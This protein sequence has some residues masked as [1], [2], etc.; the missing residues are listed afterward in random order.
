MLNNELRQCVCC[1]HFV[2]CAGRQSS[3]HHSPG[4]SEIWLDTMFPDVI[5][6]VVITMVT[7]TTTTK[8]ES[9]QKFP[10][11]PNVCFSSILPSLTFFSHSSLCLTCQLIVK[12]RSTLVSNSSSFSANG[13]TLRSVI[14]V[15]GQQW[16]TSYC[17]NNLSDTA[18]QK[19]TKPVCSKSQFSFLSHWTIATGLCIAQFLQ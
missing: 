12:D 17:Q 10:S 19:K 4:K 5:S 2:L 1:D 11:A 9:V 16:S 13:L 6:L 3:F 7:L 14:R 8:Q 18:V 15:V